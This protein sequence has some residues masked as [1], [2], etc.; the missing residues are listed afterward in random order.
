MSAREHIV[1]VQN[2]NTDGENMF[3]VLT[4]NLWIVMLAL[5]GCFTTYLAWYLTRAKR[6]SPIT[7]IEAKQLWTIHRHDTHCDGR[8]WQQL[9]NGKH[10][11]GFQC[12][13]G[14]R[15]IQKRPLVAHTPA[16][17][18]TA[19]VSAFDKLHTTHKSA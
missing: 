15:H 19:Q 3:E 1:S 18:G 2:I 14:Y 4:S 9:K 16:T 8:K 12:E 5:W 17:L 6:F 11:V 10:A 7:P 13:C